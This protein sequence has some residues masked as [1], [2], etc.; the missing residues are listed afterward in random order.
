[1]TSPFEPDD[2]RI[3]NTGQVVYAATGTTVPALT[4]AQNELTEFGVGF[5]S[6]GLF[7][8]DAVEHEMDEDTEEITTWQAGVVKIIVKGRKLTLK[9]PAMQSSIAVVEEFY[10]ASFVL[11][12]TEPNQVARMPIRNT[13]ARL[14][15]LY[16][17]EWI[18]AATEAIWRLQFDRGQVG[19][20]ESPTF[21]AQ[22]AV[23]WGMTLQALG[24]GLS[25]DSELASWTTN[26]LS[27]LAALEA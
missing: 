3:A 15:R 19:E 5:S 14:T 16:I 21:N 10:G 18:D 20:V 24:T 1:M 23:K 22:G 25:A 27:I 11:V 13:Q 2:I 4:P 17:F 6:L 9:V 12:G 7:D 8:P 26:D